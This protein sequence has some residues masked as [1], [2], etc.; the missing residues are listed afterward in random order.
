VVAVAGVVAWL[1]WPFFL[2]LFASDPSSGS[3]AIKDVSKAETFKLGDNLGFGDTHR[4]T[5]RVTGQLDGTAGISNPITGNT[6][7]PIGGT[8]DLEWSG[9]YYTNRAD[10]RY[11]PQDVRG[12]SLTIAYEF[13]V[14]PSLSP[15][16]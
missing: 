13:H 7:T 9:D 4:V 10:I 14:V 8:V 1:F 12:G 2:A 16:N 3:I 5:I 15:S 6:L 11:V